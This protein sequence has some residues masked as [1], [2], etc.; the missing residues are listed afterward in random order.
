MLF[1]E[2]DSFIKFEAGLLDNGFNIF[3]N[4]YFFFI[5]SWFRLL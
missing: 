4:I 5:S 1:Y 3:N 2:E